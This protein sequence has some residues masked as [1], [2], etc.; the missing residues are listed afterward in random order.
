VLV[1]DFA[2][3][4]PVSC[5]RILPDIVMHASQSSKGDVPDSK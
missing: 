3:V 1:S 4:T 5:G 2:A